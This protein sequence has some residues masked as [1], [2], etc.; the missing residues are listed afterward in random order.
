[1]RYF[2]SCG[3]I[4][5]PQMALCKVYA[6]A[7]KHNDE[8]MAKAELSSWL[9]WA[10]RCRLEPFKK[11]AS[12]L[13]QR[14][15]G[16]VRSMLDNRSNAYVEAMNSLLQQAKRAARGFRTTT[17]FIAIAYLPMSKLKHLPSNPLES[18]LPEYNGLIHR[19]L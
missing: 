19:C 9:S 16:V 14:L 5:Y 12:T 3:W 2:G 10:T 7:A 4:S 15:A 13:K 1:M 11:L 6:N 8:A 18:A 17:N